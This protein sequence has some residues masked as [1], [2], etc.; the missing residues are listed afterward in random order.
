MGVLATTPPVH[1]RNDSPVTVRADIYPAK[2]SFSF[3]EHN[4]PNMRAVVTLNEV[5]VLVEGGTSILELYRAPL[6]D[7]Q[8]TRTSLTATTEDGEVVIRK[9]GGNC[10][11]GSSL[12]SYR[13]FGNATRM[14]AVRAR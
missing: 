3:D 6:L 10:G 13:P 5:L 4:Y 9:D 11:C 7:V 8:G 1:R 12:K 2:V 14:A